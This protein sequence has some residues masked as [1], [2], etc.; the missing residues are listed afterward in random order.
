VA[1]AG[2]LD[3]EVA[4]VEGYSE[5]ESG[6]P[7]DTLRAHIDHWV[8]EAAERFGEFSVGA[9]GFVMELQV[10]GAVELGWAYG[11]ALEPGAESLFARAA[12][13]ARG[14]RGDG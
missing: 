1:A 7:T 9:Y 14:G 2:L 12:E 4:Y 3:S 8:D 11:G 13:Q 6:D 10:D 5:E